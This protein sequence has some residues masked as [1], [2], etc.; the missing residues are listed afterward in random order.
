MGEFTFA[1]GGSLRLGEA[2]ESGIEMLV[3]LAGLVFVK[4]CLLLG[5]L[6]SEDV[7]LWGS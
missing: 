5:L 1:P 4:A 7:M 3:G 2:F 6:Y